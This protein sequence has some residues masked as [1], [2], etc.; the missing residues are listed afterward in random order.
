[1]HSA[2]ISPLCGCLP[3]ILVVDD[4]DFN[5]LVVKLLL[6]SQH[7]IVPEEAQNGQIAVELVE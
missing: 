7:G 5:V 4:T 6:D 3:S 2:S 1:M